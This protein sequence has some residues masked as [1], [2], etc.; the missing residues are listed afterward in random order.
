MAIGSDVLN[1]AVIFSAIDRLT[2]PVSRMTVG[3]NKFQQSIYYA[4]RYMQDMFIKTSIAATGIIAVTK[5]M[6]DAFA[7]TETA[8]ANMTTVLNGDIEKADN[9]LTKI[10]D[11]AA[12]S[13]LTAKPLVNSANV[14]LSYG[15]EEDKIM[16]T[17]QQLGDL[18]K[19][20]DDV[21][22]SL[23]MGYGRIVAENRVTREHLDR[24]VFKG[25]IPIY[26]A[27]AKT[28]GIS[29]VD[30]AKEMQAGRVTGEHLIA[31]VNNLTDKGGEFYKAMEKLTATF[32]GQSQQF[33]EKFD[34]VL[35]SI[36]QVITPFLTR[37]LM[38][39][40]NPLLEVMR[41]KINS[42]LAPKVEYFRP[43]N[44]S[45]TEDIERLRNRTDISNNEKAMIIEQL[46][47]GNIV[48]HV[49]DT[50]AV[51][52]IWK[53]FN[54]IL[55]AL[56]PKNWDWLDKI[57]TN[58]ENGTSLFYDF[59]DVIAAF[60]NGMKFAL[61]FFLLITTMLKPFKGIIGFLAGM[62][63]FFAPLSFIFVKI[64]SLGSGLLSV[65]SSIFK[66]LFKFQSI[67][68]LFLRLYTMFTMWYQ[69]IIFSF[70]NFGI[71]A[72]V[73]GWLIGI[74]TAV[75]G[76]LAAIA[77]TTVGAIGLVVS[78]VAGLSLVFGQL[79]KRFE[80]FRKF[81][82][83]FTGFLYNIADRL[84]ELGGLFSWIGTAIQNFANVLRAFFQGDLLG[85]LI[86]LGKL[87]LDFFLNIFHMITGLVGYLLSFLIE[88]IKSFL[89]KGLVDFI[90]GF[91]GTITGFS[92]N[93]QKELDKRA[94]IQEEKKK[95][96]QK[97]KEELKNNVNVEVHNNNV[98]NTSDPNTTVESE[99]YFVPNVGKLPNGVILQ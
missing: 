93:I 62:L 14:L 2:R 65:F 59:I 27:L 95:D 32:E 66:F 7:W 64:A 70:K 48:K 4:D 30:L 52:N 79:Y 84:K 81:V 39:G 72:T 71:L 6:V 46:E 96:E 97:E 15:I 8:L 63:V 16:D 19:G 53:A 40:F 90:E 42:V 26:K 33:A 77:G 78:A 87:V 36:G 35:G 85:I 50:K 13:P 74:F 67:K 41:G 11:M 92:E 89:P 68:L 22:E 34:L 61:K 58:L 1:V 88:K 17:L 20:R 24:F 91:F 57:L 76:T 56:I 38:V 37:A 44:Y 9:L 80:W 25:N 99:S 83:G 51:E 21:L 5:Q 3:M 69:G 73:K 60:I 86:A 47:L 10:R 82:D 29:E 75:K 28:M 31:A 12:N 94:G 49:T 43:E 23:A 18:S 54:K 55:D 98:I 45:K